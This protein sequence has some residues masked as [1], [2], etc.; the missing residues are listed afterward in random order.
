MIRRIDENQYGG[1][2]FCPEGIILKVAVGTALHRKHFEIM[3]E[4]RIVLFVFQVNPHAV[5]NWTDHYII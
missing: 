1:D 4:R 5:Q 3:E 2:R